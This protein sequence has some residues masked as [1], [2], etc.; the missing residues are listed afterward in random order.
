MKR[1]N[2]KHSKAVKAKISKA[3]IGNTN[4]QIYSFEEVRGLLLTGIELAKNTK[5]TNSKGVEYPK[6]DFLGEVFSEL[7]TYYE[8]VAG[9]IRNHDNEKGEL[10]AL[11]RRLKRQL[12]TNCY[13]NGKNNKINVSMSIL[14]LKSNHKWQDRVDVTSKNKQ[15]NKDNVDMGVALSELL[16]DLKK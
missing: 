8:E 14:N 13:L 15:L 5:I 16:K 11:Y 7:N 3:L 9:M 1:K 2:T 4:P 12:E 6:F 10:K